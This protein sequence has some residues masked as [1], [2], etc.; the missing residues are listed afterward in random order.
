[1]AKFEKTLIKKS[2]GLLSGVSANLSQPEVP[3]A[4]A[5]QEEEKK[6]EIKVHPADHSKDLAVISPLQ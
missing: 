6:E 1:L 2:G 4:E 3:Q 5:E